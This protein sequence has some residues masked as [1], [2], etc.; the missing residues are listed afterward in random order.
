M[1]GPQGAGF[2]LLLMVVFAAL[3]YWLVV[4]KQVVLRVLAA[5]LAFVPA[6][7]FGIASVN[8]F[9]D[10]YQTWGGMISDLTGQGASSIPK[11]A[12]AGSN[13]QFDKDI[14]RV[15]S[16]AED[17]QVGYLFQTTIVGPRTRL[18]RNVY[19]YLPPQ[20]F[21]KAYAHYK[22]PAIELLHGSPGNPQ[23]WLSVL[24]VIPTY[25]N[26]LE[27]HPSDAAVL[28]MPDTDGGHQY[29]LQCLNNP[30]GIQDLTFVAEDVPDYIARLVRVQP[31]G[32]AWGVAGYSEG[33]YCA[34]NIAMREP[35]RY[36]AAGVISGYFAPIQSGVPAGNKPGGKPVT[37][38]VFAGHQALQS[39][40]SPSAYIT[41][42]S[43][44]VRLP[45]FWLAAGA[46][47]KQDVSLAANFRQLVL[48]RL[49]L[50]NRLLLQNRPAN[51]PF[52]VVPGGGHTGSV[53]RAALGPMLA[54]MTPQLAA[55]AARA[56]AAAAAAAQRQANPL[57]SAAA[58]PSAKPKK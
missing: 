34:A 20:Y 27:G 36:G 14:G 43:L 22:F 39:L 58:P 1:F 35:E 33:G 44:S 40:N 19:V 45:A 50:Q 2:F 25:L 31:P 55:Q 23:A 48:T 10:Y 53:W 32:L 56:D 26:L 42:L 52:M 9:Y 37:V 16:T 13:R 11:Y 15:T 30:G 24:D 4:A 28:V 6:M 3:I 8:K 12:V 17:A 57:K 7:A 29:G 18:A 51:V 5:C 38:N 46:E 54:W 47:D 41:K 21:Q 49:Q